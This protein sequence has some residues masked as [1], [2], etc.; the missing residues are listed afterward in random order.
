LLRRLGKSKRAKASGVGCRLSGVK[1]PKPL[2]PVQ[3]H[4]GKTGICC[5]KYGLFLLQAKSLTVQL[6]FYKTISLSTS[7]SFPYASNGNPASLRRSRAFLNA[8]GVKSHWTPRSCKNRNSR[9]KGLFFVL[10]LVLVLVLS[11]FIRHT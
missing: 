7:P 5:L 10:P 11:L 1:T 2:V 8:C 9:R 6:S 4:Y 3:N